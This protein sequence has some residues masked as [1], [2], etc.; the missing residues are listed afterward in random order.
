LEIEKL[1]ET[2]KEYNDRYIKLMIGFASGY[3]IVW[4]NVHKYMIKSLEFLSLKFMLITA[5]LFLA[6]EVSQMIILQIMYIRVLNNKIKDPNNY[7]KVT[8]C[9]W[10]PILIATIILGGLGIIYLICGIK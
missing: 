4:L 6:S 5:T 9:I 8:L 3:F 7:I 10:I 1:N 2:V